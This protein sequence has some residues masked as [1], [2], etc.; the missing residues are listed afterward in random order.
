MISLSYPTRLSGSARLLG[1]CTEWLKCQSVVWGISGFGAALGGLLVFSPLIDGG[2]TQ[3]PVLII[4]MVLLVS[5]VIW[6]LGRMKTGELFL[7]QTRVDT[8]VALFAGWAI[9]S[10]VWSPYKNASV[11]WVLS[12]LSYAALFVHGHAWHSIAGADLD[13][14]VRRDWDG[15][16]SKA[17]GE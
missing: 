10:L 8:C 2:T 5:G 12:I 9:L 1:R 4:R 17:C 7:P 16:R 13:A 14:P 15:H 6:L 3:L 11:Q